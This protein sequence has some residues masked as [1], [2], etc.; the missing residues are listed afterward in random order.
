MG[1]AA[2]HRGNLTEAERLFEQAE[3]LLASINDPYIKGQ[4]LAHQ[5]EVFRFRSEWAQAEQKFRSA[6]Q[7]FLEIEDTTESAWI[8]KKLGLLYLMQGHWSEGIHR[9]EESEEVF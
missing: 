8:D 1:S 2:L 9:L 4:I 6:N 3:G 7:T 5:G